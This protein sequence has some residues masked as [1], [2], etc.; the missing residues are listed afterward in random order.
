MEKITVRLEE[1]NSAARIEEPVGL[2]IPL[3]KGTVQAI[4]Q[5]ALMNGRE[6]ITVQLEPL[7]HWPD[8]S[9][10]WV[11]ASFLISLDSGQVKDL[12]LVKLQE[13]NATTGHEPAIEQ[14]SDGF[15]VHTSTGS[16]VL[17][18]N[19]LGWQVAQQNNPT[20]SS[21][22]ILNDD[23]SLPCTAKA[24]ANWEITCKGPIFVSS[25][26]KGQWLK[27]NNEPLARFECELKIFLETGL[28][29]VELTTH[30]PKR[31]RH[32]GGLWDLGDAGSV[33]F[34]E[35]AID[36]TLPAKCLTQITP[37]ATDKEPERIQF[38]DFNLYQDSSGGENW[39]S[40]NHT[41]ANGKI[42]T[43]F[44]GYR[45][46]NPND[47]VH[48]GKRANP[49]ISIEYDGGTFDLAVPGFWQNFPTGLRKEDNKLTVGLFPKDFKKTYELQGG[50]RKTL[51]CIMA[52]SSKSNTV[53]AAYTPLVPVLTPECYERASAFPWFKANTQPDALDQ[54][55]TE[56]LNGNSN[57]FTKREVIDE[58]GWRNFGDIFAD[59]ETLYQAEGDAPFI[60]HYNNQYDAIYGFARQFAMNGDKRWFEL[61]DDLAQH[62]TD[63]DI[64][65]TDQDRGEYNNG[66]FWH[67]DHYLDAQTATHRTFTRHN[68]TSSTPGQTGG[69][70]AAEHCYTTG[71]MY[72]YML[73]GSKASKTATLEL[74]QWMVTNHE[75]SGGLLE[76]VLALKNRELPRMSA[77]ARG[78]TVTTHS[79][80]F[81]RGTGNYLTALIDA[82]ILE[83]ENDW[84]TRAEDVI[85]NTIH[86]K[87]NIANRDLLNV[88][89]GWSYLILLSS[90][91]RYLQ[92]KRARNQL[93]E[94][95]QFA[96]AS[97][98][99]YT[100]WMQQNER[101]FLADTAQL[102]FANHTW[103]AQ[104]IRKAMLIF[105]AAELVSQPE[106]DSLMSTAQEWLKQV[107]DTLKNS[108]ERHYSRI[109]V[110]LM[111]N[112]GPHL[113]AIPANHNAPLKSPKLIGSKPLKLTWRELI[114]R[115]A[116]RMVC[117]IK[118]LNIAKEKAWLDTR[119][120]KK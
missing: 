11:H 7:A 23:A 14:T 75:G 105:Q 112:Y 110:I 32:P 19:S 8:G 80:P 2:G 115:I 54:L 29:H 65:H 59:H 118:H 69:G 92:E 43:Q 24:D 94:S 48:E 56:G 98:L 52:H 84:L 36:T 22:V 74:A 111:Q 108:E 9:L 45:L 89:T 58:F 103:V 4:H 101:R 99:A 64:Y 40:R 100:N 77:L 120:D 73:T 41:D 25:T 95:Y 46:S 116:G 37:Q 5:L 16:V 106:A 86:P 85:K 62:V 6:P 21:T 51:R 90:I 72:H 82:S 13:L 67:T 30:N 107:C 81:T 61:M 66:L 34:R 70:P 44:C 33:Y 96:T 17:A 42:T 119:R 3:P 76:S 10:R 104:D 1:K 83:P 57:F 31:A 18:F 27:Q 39:Q 49:L 68:D 79:Y 78:N 50:E 97:L 114:G 38:G 91:A 12:E 113:A 109:L 88:E 55:L 47:L 71:L 102:E 15:V 20:T 53:A 87:D 60:S 93:D 117:S 63:V 26:L 28:I 35:L